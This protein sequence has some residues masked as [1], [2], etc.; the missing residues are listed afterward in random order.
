MSHSPAAWTFYRGDFNDNGVVNNQ[1]ITAIRNEWKGKNGAR[2]TIFGEILGNGTV[3]AADYHA[4]K[5]LNGT[6]LP[7]LPKHGGKPPH[8]VLESALAHRPHDLTHPHHA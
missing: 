4:A 3:T 8:A 7:K 2:P 1:D 6:K 5:K